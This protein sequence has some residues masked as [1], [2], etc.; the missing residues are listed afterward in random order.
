MSHRL[1]S[2]VVVASLLVGC[3]TT[4]PPA[5]AP[6]SST[7][8]PSTAGPS[9]T[10]PPSLTMIVLPP[11]EPL[12]VRSA[13]PGQRAVFLVRVSGGDA[14]EPIV[15]AAEAD[16][17]TVEIAPAII[18]EGTV[19][20]VTVIP[21]PATTES[22]VAVTITAR[23]GALDQTETRTVPVWPETDTLEPE[24]RDRLAAFTGWLSD[25]R[26]ELGIDRDTIWTG[27]ALQPKMLVVSHYLFMSEDWEAALEWHVMIA[28]DD[29][30]R[31]ILRRRWIE[32]RPSLAF[33]IASVSRGDDPHQIA[34]PEA[35]PPTRAPADQ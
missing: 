35:V 1:W 20:E 33:E 23:R 32:D 2:L 7:P 19:A 5:T 14:S 13:V 17:G 29:W 3:T 21:G 25:E 34:P 18:E 15:L 27:T 6:A 9:A 8:P 30:Q 11:E 26:P 24:A 22:K 16:G 12:D 31:I 4:G 28:P 10:A